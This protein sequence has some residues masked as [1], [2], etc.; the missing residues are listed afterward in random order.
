MT[1]LSILT[2][3]AWQGSPSQRSGWR[4]RDLQRKLHSICSPAGKAER[5][6]L[7]E[8]VSCRFVSDSGERCIREIS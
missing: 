3:N 1:D 5:L 6:Q 8:R 7:H 2:F 4:R